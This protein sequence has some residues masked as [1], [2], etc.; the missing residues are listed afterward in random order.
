MDRL[1]QHNLQT[2]GLQ[3]QSS[4]RMMRRLLISILSERLQAT[5]SHSFQVD[6]TM[7][8]LLLTRLHRLQRRL[9]LFALRQKQ[10]SI[11][12][13]ATILARTAHTH[14]S[15]VRTSSTV[16]TWSCLS[17]M[18][19]APQTPNS[20]LPYLHGICLQVLTWQPTST[21][22]LVPMA[23]CQDLSPSQRLRFLHSPQALSRQSRHPQMLPALLRKATASTPSKEQQ[24]ALPSTLSTVQRWYRHP[25]TLLTSVPLQTVCTSSVPATPHSKL[26]D[27]QTIKKTTYRKLK[28]YY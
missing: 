5:N 3:I 8:D 16:T 11:G 7:L 20:P 25:A 10:K 23:P 18:S 27:K 1:P 21:A 28:R 6:T 24:K 22:K 4:Y 15:S 9:P 13:R 17:N 19:Q 2:S 12:R 26:R 14:L